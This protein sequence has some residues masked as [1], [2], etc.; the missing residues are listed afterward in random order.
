MKIHRIEGFRLFQHR[1]FITGIFRHVDI[2]SPWSFRQGDYLAHELFRTRIFWHRDITA[3]IHFGTW[4]FRQSGCFSKIT[5]F[6]TGAKKSVPKH[7]YCFV[8]C[9]NFPVP[10]CP[11]Q[12]KN[13]STILIY[14]IHRTVTYC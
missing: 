7:P 4:I 6:C 12:D 9:Q 8:W 11:C 5:H 14:L 10:K 1:H 3:L 13:F 2:S